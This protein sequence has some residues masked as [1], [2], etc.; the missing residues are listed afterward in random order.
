MNF[1]ALRSQREF[2][3]RLQVLPTAQH[4][5]AAEIGVEELMTIYV[6]MGVS[7]PKKAPSVVD[8]S[9]GYLTPSLKQP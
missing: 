2:R 6:S 8:P 4:S 1:L 5:D 3:K 9:G 7:G